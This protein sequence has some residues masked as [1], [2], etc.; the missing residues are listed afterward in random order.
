MTP[1]LKCKSSNITR[2][3]LRIPQ[4]TLHIKES[5]NRRT[6]LNLPRNTLKQNIQEQSRKNDAIKYTDLRFVTHAVS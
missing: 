2:L 4:D 1:Y 3:N 6:Y 5:R